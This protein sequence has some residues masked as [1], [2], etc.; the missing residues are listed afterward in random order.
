MVKDD[1]CRAVDHPI[2]TIWYPYNFICHGV[3]SEVNNSE[4][5]IHLEDA[6]E[7]LHSHPDSFREWPHETPR[8]CRYEKER[9]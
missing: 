9:T 8:W 2:G 1:D 5:S 3:W 6:I 7:Y 4:V